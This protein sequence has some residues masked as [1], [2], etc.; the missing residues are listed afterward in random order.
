MAGTSSRRKDNGGLVTERGGEEGEAAVAELV[1]STGEEPVATAPTTKPWPWSASRHARQA[2]ASADL[3]DPAAQP[4][5]IT[6]L[7][8][9]GHYATVVPAIAAAAWITQPPLRPRLRPVPSKPMRK[10]L[11]ER[12]SSGS[13]RINLNGELTMERLHRGEGVLRLLRTTASAA[14]SLCVATRERRS[15]S[16]GHDEEPIEPATVQTEPPYVVSL[17]SGDTS[18]IGLGFNNAA[19][20]EQNSQGLGI[21]HSK[22]ITEFN[23]NSVSDVLRSWLGF[24]SESDTAADKS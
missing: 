15:S 16:G 5:A 20:I 1:T 14:A 22:L 4:N 6:A 7:G 11:G 3:L 24:D 8:R 10:E 12:V 18:T 9:L 17:P 13:E 2:A 21:N 19:C 23:S